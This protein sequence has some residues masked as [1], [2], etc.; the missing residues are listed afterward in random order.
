MV[1]GIDPGLKGGIAYLDDHGGL[2]R[3]LSIPTIQ[4]A[5]K[6]RT[7][8]V[9]DEE[10]L[11]ELFDSMQC[12]TYCIESNIIIPTD[13][14]LSQVAS[15]DGYGLLRGILRAL[16]KEIMIV[17][18]KGWQKGFLEG[19][20]GRHEV[21]KKSVAVAKKLFPTAVLEGPRGAALDG[22]SD[23]LLIA[24]YARRK[25]TGGDKVD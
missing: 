13:G 21:K 24:E 10:A 1:C 9:Y 4:I 14:R 11:V 6:K 19:A 23:A 20:K 22:L 16:R 5:G 12:R 15:G 17:S 3:L 18:P 25:I 7:K 2:V 8:R